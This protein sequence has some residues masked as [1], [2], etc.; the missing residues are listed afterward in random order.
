MPEPDAPVAL[1]VV[2]HGRVQ[3][4]WF[5]GFTV[6]NARELGVSGWVRNRKDGTVEALF[7]GADQIV[8]ELLAR[9]TKGP[10]AAHVTNVI[11]TPDPMP[12]PP[13]EGFVQRR[14]A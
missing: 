8:S 11:S 10:P 3:G 1:M 12:S 6:R 2:F 4:V 13:P 7:T 5:R 9:C 14:T